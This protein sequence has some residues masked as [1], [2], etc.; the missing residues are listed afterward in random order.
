MTVGDLTA[1]LSTK[2]PYV[3]IKKEVAEEKAQE[4]IAAM[5][6]ARLRGLYL[7]E[8]SVRSYPNGEMLCHVLGFVDHSGHGI[9]GI[10]KSFD[11]ETERS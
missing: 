5:E 8:G 4:M 7:E 3:V 10:E 11:P 1:K 2:R 6:K 9:D